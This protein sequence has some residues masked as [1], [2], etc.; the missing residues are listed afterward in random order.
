MVN[1]RL[2]SMNWDMPS[3]DRLF[4]EAA[5]TLHY[6]PPVIRKKQY[7]SVW[8][9]YALANAWSGYGWNKEVRISPTREDI[10]RLEFALE[11]GWELEKDD[12]QIIWHTVMSAVNRERGPRWKYLS[13]RFHCDPRSVKG[14]YEKALIKAYYLIKGLQ[15]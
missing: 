7:S 5:V 15:S 2:M 11:I 13:K 6:L 9:N 3:L 8:P 12:R 10:T 1:K 4:K 14:K